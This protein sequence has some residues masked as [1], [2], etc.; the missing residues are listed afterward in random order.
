M[1]RGFKS[2]KRILAGK[3]FTLIELLVVIAIIALLMSVMLPALK[4]A[5]DQ[6]KNTIC[7]TNLK[8]IGVSMGTYATD[9]KQR[10]VPGNFWN[11]TTIWYGLQG[12]STGTGWGPMNLGKLLWLINRVDIRNR[13]L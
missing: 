12:Q 8:Q 9:H 11:G 5:K 10:C 6:A 4:K 3:G 2:I 1:G 13:Q 7:M